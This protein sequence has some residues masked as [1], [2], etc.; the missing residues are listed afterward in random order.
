[1][2]LPPRGLND[3]CM[4]CFQTEQPLLGKEAVFPAMMVP[5]AT[6]SAAACAFSEYAAQ[7]HS[8]P[9]VQGFKRGAEAVLEVVEPTPQGLVHASN[10]VFQGISG[11][12]TRFHE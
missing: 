9:A 1:M 10:D 11:V 7:T 8:G 6:S 2:V 5:S 3:L 12:A 4:G